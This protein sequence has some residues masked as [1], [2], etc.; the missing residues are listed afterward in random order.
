[1]AGSPQ[2]VAT[3]TEAAVDRLIR[4]FG[5]TLLSEDVPDRG[6]A[7]REELEES[8]GL[9]DEVLAETVDEDWSRWG[10]LLRTG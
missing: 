1:M 7:L 8:D 6:Y 4:L 10:S 9:A 2:P 3:E 5:A